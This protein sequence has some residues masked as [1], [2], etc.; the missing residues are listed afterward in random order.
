GFWRWRRHRAGPARRS[1]LRVLLLAA[2]PIPAVAANSYGGEI[3]FR[4]F[5]FALPFMAIA[6]A[7]VFFPSQRTGT[8]RWTAL[9]LGATCLALAAGF[10]VGNF[11]QEAIDYFTPGEVA[12][13]AWLYRTAPP[14]TQIVA[15][16]S[17]FP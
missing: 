11:G 17:D 15:A 8:S 9:A 4:V 6:G 1:W 10:C 2:A 7:A 12:A 14:G 3:I 16:N 5:L 13:S